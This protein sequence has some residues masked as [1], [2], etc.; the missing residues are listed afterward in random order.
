MANLHQI[1]YA[2]SDALDL[3]GVDDIY[4]GK[5]VAYMALET[6]KELELRKEDYIDILHASL[7]HD[8]G[9]SSS[10]IHDKLV[11]TLDWEGAEDH[12]I[13]GYQL[14]NLSKEL[15][16]LSNIVLYHHTHYEML[17]ELN[18]DFRTARL[19]NLIFM[20]DR[21]DAL[22]AQHKVKHK[23]SLISISE[24]VSNEIKNLSGSF[25]DEELVQAFLNVSKKESFWFTLEEENLHRYFET[26][27]RELGDINI[28]LRELEDVAKLF[29]LF[30][31]AKSPYTA[32]HSMDVAELSKFIA[33]KMELDFQTSEMI[34]IAGLLH[35]LGKLKVP[36][37]LIDKEAPLTHD[38]FNTI[39]IHAYET[40]QILSKING[41]EEITEWASQ[42]HE[43]LRGTGYPYHQEQKDI[44]LPSRIIGVADI[45]QALAQ[46]RPYRKGLKP[47]QIL[48]ILKQKVQD[49]ELDE[50]V[51]QTVETNVQ[52]CWEISIKHSS[53]RM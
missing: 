29:A 39:K 36:D 20:V 45:F 18:I 37:E 16:H 35:D 19:A 47:L 40:H 30:V 27:L 22:T 4:H 1:I 21:I 5:R 3:V 24:S 43:N 17:K 48:K 28:G 15:K 23:T 7:L 12:C 6:A 26:Y 53:H 46:D 42:H 49:G 33:L 44:S 13:R 11:F 9:V 31:D 52:Q 41:L 10:R 2:L 34:K 8:C 14:L 38:E 25:F 51:V 32:D 50:D